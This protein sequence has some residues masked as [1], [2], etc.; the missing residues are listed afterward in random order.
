MKLC[1]RQFPAPSNVPHRAHNFLWSCLETWIK[2]RMNPTGPWSLPITWKITAH[3]QVDV[4]RKNTTTTTAMAEVLRIHQKRGKSESSKWEQAFEWLFPGKKVSVDAIT[5]PCSSNKAMPCPTLMKYLG[6]TQ[7]PF[8]L[9]AVIGLKKA[10]TY[11]LAVVRETWYLHKH[12]VPR[13][14]T[15]SHKTVWH[16]SHLHPIY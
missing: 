12:L 4:W 5:S 6:F 8:F 16:T 15:K 1:Q 3:F 7:L 11:S 9:A 2:L 13:N 10:C 14:Q